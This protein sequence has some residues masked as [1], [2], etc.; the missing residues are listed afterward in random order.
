MLGRIE[1]E[2]SGLP[3]AKGLTGSVYFD[4]AGG[5]ADDILE[6]LQLIIL[7]GHA[8]R[9]EKNHADGF[10]SEGFEKGSGGGLVSLPG[11]RPNPARG[12]ALWQRSPNLA[13]QVPH[14][15]VEALEDCAEHL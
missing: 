1:A 5:G 9:V 14:R 10:F 7:E 12:G 15:G 13:H 6:H 8:L 3:T 2:S 11:A 4:T